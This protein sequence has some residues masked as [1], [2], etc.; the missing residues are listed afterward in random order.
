MAFDN[1]N[2]R[3]RQAVT[4]HE[5]PVLVLAGAGS[6]KTT[7]LIDRVAYLIRER[8]IEPW[9][10]LAITFTKKAAGEMKA[11]LERQLGAEAR[12]VWAFTFHAACSKILRRDIDK[13]GYSRDFTVYDSDDSLRVLKTCLAEM[14]LDDKQ[15][16]PRLVMSTI[17][18][19]KNALV[20]PTTYEEHYGG[21]GNAFRVR[22]EADLYKRYN[23][24]LKLANALDFDDIL[25][26]VVRLFNECPAV[27]EY[28]QRRF[29]TLM[30]D[31]YQD[32]NGLQY[33]LCRQ[34]A[35]KHRSFFVVG[36]DDQ[37]IYRFRGATIRNILEFEQ[38]YPDAV[39]IRLEQNYRSTKNILA[40]A[41]H[42]IGHNKGRKG[43]T[44]WTAGNSGEPIFVYTAPTSDDEGAFVAEKILDGIKSGRRYNDFAI[45]YRINA[46]ANQ[47]EDALRRRGVP[48]RIIGGTRFDDTM[49]IR[50]VT[51]YLHVL[52]NPSDNLRLLR[53]FNT[54]ARGIG[55]KTVDTISA[56]AEAGG[57][58]I[59]DVLENLSAHPELS[60]A[61][62]ALS[63]FW[64]MI[65]AVREKLGTASLAELYDEMLDKTGYLHM[66]QSKRD[67]I[68]DGRVENIMEFKSTI[69]RY[70]ESCAEAG[71]TATL[72]GFLET[73]ALLEAVENYDADADAVVLMTIHSSKGLEFP[74]VFLIGMEEGLFPGNRAIGDPEEIEEERRLCYVAITRAR[75]QLH[76]T[77]AKSRLMFG[78]TEYHIKSRFLE[79]LPD[80]CVRNIA[81]ERKAKP[82]AADT[83]RHMPKPVLVAPPKAAKVDF[84]VG[85]N[86]EH[87]AFG[88]G[89]V[90]KITPMGGDAL[91]EIDFAVAGTK[92]LMLKAAAPYLKKEAKA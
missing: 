90:A 51:A 89:V 52:N 62:N 33:Q 66:Y 75:E 76:I 20:V 35:A 65:K 47:I 44:L 3:Q 53:V 34:L 10:V 11:R 26:N 15:F 50:D 84:S 25:L 87:K 39:V 37:S 74:H 77:C 64:S 73:R 78:R 30:V 71:E 59:A 17:S 38:E 68:S 80:D 49:E 91:I 5:G 28:Y 61:S 82:V 69:A 29:R 45:L 85:D 16:P 92:R 9:S 7:V 83:V 48:Y 1:L 13:I 58:S 31:E 41:N 14:N 19:A 42:V 70:E 18:A 54:P 88:V 56:I 21:E 81:P 36:D 60:R 79:E 32:T 24:K 2:D 55:D 86:V 27:L 43:K 46:Q 12:D 6:G 67:V 4:A 22:K 23:D 63:A 72:A 40:A 57:V 8:G